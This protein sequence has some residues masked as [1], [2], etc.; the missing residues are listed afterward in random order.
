MRALLLA[1]GRG[2][3]LTGEADDKPPKSLLQFGGQSLLA[4]HI[5]ILQQLGVDALTI[6]IGYRQNDILGEI[7][8]IAPSLP[9]E[10]IENSRFHEG[11]LVSLWHARERLTGGEDV[12]LMD[13]DVLYGPALLAPLIA[14]GKAD[15]LSYDRDFEAGDEPVKLCMKNGTA[16]E[17]RK[18]VDVTY[19]TVGEWPGFARL[20]ASSAAKLAGHLQEFID[21][22][23]V[24]APYEEAFRT[25]LLE[26]PAGQFAYIDITG[27]PWIEID[28][29][30]DVIRAE[31]EILPLLS[32]T[33]R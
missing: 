5:E 2:V 26:A 22:G 12:L 33:G 28:F 30:E 25:L 23:E 18:I 19:D 1:A 32:A 9:I 31:R 8:A 20:E 15:C 29:P 4:R 21:R 24:N 6:V 16:V 10:T 3:R 11:S 17:F 13:A 27:T 7:S 14:S